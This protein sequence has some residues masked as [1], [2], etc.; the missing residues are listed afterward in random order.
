MTI[1][2]VICKV[3][4]QQLKQLPIIFLKYIFSEITSDNL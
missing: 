3:Q 4:R 2:K 1:Y